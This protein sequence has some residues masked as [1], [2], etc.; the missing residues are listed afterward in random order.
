MKK[1]K[2]SINNSDGKGF[3]KLLNPL[4]KPKQESNLEEILKE[5]EEMCETENSTEPVK[6][7]E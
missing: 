1:E 2:I 4:V 7:D 3:S 6:K 5:L